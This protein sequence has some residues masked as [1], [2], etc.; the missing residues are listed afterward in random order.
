MATNRKKVIHI[1]SNV[2]GKQPV[3]DSLEYGELALNYNSDGGFISYKNSRQEVARISDD[4]TMSSLMEY[5]EVVPYKAE[6]SVTDLES[7][8]SE[9]KV[10]LN[11]KV[12][13]K[14][15]H[16]DEINAAKGFSISMDGYVMNGSSPEFKNLTVS[17]DTTLNNLKASGN[18]ELSKLEVTDKAVINSLTVSGDTDLKNLTVDGDT[19]VKNFKVEGTFE[20]PESGNTEIK[21]ENVVIGGK[22]VTISGETIAVYRDKTHVGNPLSSATV[23]DA[24]DETF[25]RSKVTI[26]RDDKNKLY[27]I[28]QDGEIRGSINET[29]SPYK[30]GKG[31]NSAILGRDG[32]QHADGRFSVAEGWYTEAE[33]FCEHAFGIYNKS[34]TNDMDQGKNTIF[35]VGSGN[36]ENRKNAFEITRDGSI[37]MYVYTE[38]SE[39]R[40]C[41]NELLSAL[42]DK[43]ID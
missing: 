18:T 43:Y 3:S 35:S 9:I 10:E 12:G 29:E 25:E 42:I 16:A 37:Y 40:V 21:G 41:L 11:Q 27:N 38:D 31:D 33:N 32:G 20:M 15:P 24:I 34:Y 36:K 8:K 22:D 13:K 28:M 39:K 26:E 2:L 1:N 7:N 17:G 19:V 14:T 4:K 6:T 23:D 5:K 30:E